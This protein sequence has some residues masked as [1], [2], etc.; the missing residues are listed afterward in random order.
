MTDLDNRVCSRLSPG[1]RSDPEDGVGDRDAVLCTD[2]VKQSHGDAEEGHAENS[3][4]SPTPHAPQQA[5]SVHRCPGDLR[6]TLTVSTSNTSGIYLT[7]KVR[8]QLKC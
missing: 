8:E 5:D 3:T 1:S 2:G 7:N 6:R 4:T